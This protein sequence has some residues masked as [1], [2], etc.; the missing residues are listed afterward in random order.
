M[1]WTFL[2]AVVF[3]GL[4]VIGSEMV[5]SAESG[6]CY[7]RVEEIPKAGAAL[8]LGTGKYTS[9]GNINLYYQYRIDAAVEL[10]KSGKVNYILVSGDNSRKEYD[11]P[12]EMRDDLIGRGIPPEKIYLD[13]A[14]FRT[15]DSVERAKAIFSQDDIVIVSQ[16]FHNERALYIARHKGIKASALNARDV[17]SRYGFKTNLREKFARVKTILDIY[18]L[19]TKPKFYGEKVNM[20]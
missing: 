9:L 1:F 10:Y 14:G 7:D 16:A 6:H 2:T 12:T 11:E 13:Y 4:A 17:G 20:I 18:L 5:V 15:L 19:D 8:V 3:S